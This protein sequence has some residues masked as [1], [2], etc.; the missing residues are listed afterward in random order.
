MNGQT[1]IWGK[2]RD[3]PIIMNV[4][5]IRERFDYLAETRSRFL[6]TFG[7][8]GWDKFSK[9]RGASWGSMLGIFL[10]ILDVEEGWLL[11][12]AKKGTAAG[13]PDRKVT[14]YHSFEKA[15]N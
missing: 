4:A 3:I 6:E 9:D 7:K 2:R 15:C 10:H 5:E 11:Y 8:V 1:T 13:E 14:D 12:R